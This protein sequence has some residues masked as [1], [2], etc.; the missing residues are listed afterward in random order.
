MAHAI[1]SPSGASRWMA[2]TP[3]ARLEQ[4][5]PDKAGE[6]AAEGTLAHSIGERFLKM[7]LTED[8]AEKLDLQS[9]IQFISEVNKLFKPEM[10]EYCQAYADF[11]L[12][13]YA[14]AKRRNADAMIF[15]EKKIDLTQY[16]EEGFGTGDAFIIAD[17][18][19]DFIDLKY[20]KGVPV[21]AV[22]NK[23]MMVYAL[24]ALHEFELMFDIKK[25]RMT[26][27][28]PRID[29]ISEW[30]ISVEDLK[31]WA[32][33][34]LVPKAKLAYAGE[35]EFTPGAHCLFCRAKAVCKA[36]ADHQLEVLKYDF[37]DAV[38][39]TDDEIA[40]ILTK[41]DTIE[42]WLKAVETHA[43]DQAVNNG[44]QWPGFKLVEGRSVRVI[45]DEAGVEDKLVAYGFKVEQIQKPAELLG[46]TALEKVVGKKKFE[47]LLKDFVIKPA[48]KP[49]LVPL[50]D[51]RPPL[52]SLETA[53]LDFAETEVDE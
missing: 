24:G 49:T 48:G 16:I 46:I 37:R 32:A 28:Q 52:N 1:L 26:I 23:Q 34:D 8:D 35:G 27:Y 41:A 38:L 17:E 45:T 53:K 5:F 42:K 2:C 40:D 3:S 7:N 43:L 22:E 33:S 50:A 31:A 15:L 19:L 30:E 44:K 29:N 6:A 25:V 12:E 13:R 14:D 47:E 20:G 11:V 9:E 4:Q 21:S 39:L 51:K 18:T 36:N 10:L